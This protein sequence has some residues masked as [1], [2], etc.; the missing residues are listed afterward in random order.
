LLP[1]IERSAGTLFAGLP[2]LSHLAD[3]PVIALAEHRWFLEDGWTWVAEDPAGTIAGFLCAERLAGNLHVSELSVHRTAQGQGLGRALLEAA[4][5]HARQAGAPAV[6]LTTFREVAW[7]APFYARLGFVMLEA[8]TAGETLQ[9]ILAEEVTHGMPPGSR[10][11]MRLE[12][13]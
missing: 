1:A 4:I 13:G 10:C 5:D 3:G 2:K 8:E 12:L 6:T 11:A 7:N 9:R